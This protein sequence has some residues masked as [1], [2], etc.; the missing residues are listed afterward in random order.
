MEAGAYAID[1]HNEASKWNQALMQNG[2]RPS[3]ALVVQMNKDGD[4]NLS[5]E[6]FERLKSQLDEQYSGHSNAGRPM[7]LEGGCNGSI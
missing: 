5:E 3:G 4:A 1:Q 6:Q 2:A 7:L